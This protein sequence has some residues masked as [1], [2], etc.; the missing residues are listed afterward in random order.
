M[1]NPG[2][3]PNCVYSERNLLLNIK[4]VYRCDKEMLSLC[5]LKQ[6]SSFILSTAPY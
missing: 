1:R 2:A 6:N 3:N 4:C 5:A